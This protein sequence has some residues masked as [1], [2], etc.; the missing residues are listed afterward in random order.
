MTTAA[1]P[2][3]WPKIALATR[4]QTPRFTT[5]IVLAGSGPLKSA[6]LHPSDSFPGVAGL[7]TIVL[8]V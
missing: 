6:A 1:A 7:S 3:C 8:T 2:A 5:A 4:A